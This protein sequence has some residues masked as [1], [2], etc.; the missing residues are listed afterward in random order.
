MVLQACGLRLGRWPKS[1]SEFDD[2]CADDQLT[3]TSEMPLETQDPKITAPIG[4]RFA[5]IFDE[6]VK[7]A[8]EYIK[9]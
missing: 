4:E 3:G 9:K 8:L 2:G 1:Q 6:N 5:P 7:L